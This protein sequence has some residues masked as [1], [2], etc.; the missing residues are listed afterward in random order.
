[1][2][3]GVFVGHG[4][5]I[6]VPLPEPYGNAV[7]SVVG[8]PA[9]TATSTLSLHDALPI[10]AC[11]SVAGGGSFTLASGAS[12]VNVYY[13]D[14]KAGTPSVSLSNASSLNNPPAQVETVIAA[15]AN[16]LVFTTP[17]RTY[18]AGVCGGAGGVITG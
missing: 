5:V 1:F 13:R 17:A 11:G 6:V 18:T 4:S 16:R 14:T 7:D 8:G 15:G 9:F 10:S 3:A 12:T 2:A